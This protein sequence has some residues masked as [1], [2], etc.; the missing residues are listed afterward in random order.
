MKITVWNMI[1]DRGVIY[2][3]HIENG[4]SDSVYPKPKKDEYTNQK[5][6]ENMKWIKKYAYLVNDVV[7]CL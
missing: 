4:W 3:N 5:A 7:A 6:W 2:F 1:N